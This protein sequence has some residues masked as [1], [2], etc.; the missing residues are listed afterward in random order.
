MIT[1][2]IVFS[3]EINLSY[4]NNGNMIQGYG[5]YYEYNGFNQL[6]QVRETNIIGRILEQYF[7]DSDGNR[8]E[9]IEFYV[10]GSNQTTYYIRKDFI[11]VV[12]IS[13][14]FNFSYYYDENALIARKDSDGKKYYYHSD[15]LGS[16]DTVTNITGDIVE[17][18]SYLP[19]GEV[20]DGG[21]SRFLYTGQEKDMGTGLYYYG[22][23]YYDPSFKHFI[24][25]DTVIGDI[26]NPQD[27]NHYSYV[28]N[29]PYRY[30]DLQD[31]LCSVLGEL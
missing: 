6:K 7:Y 17:K 4:D 24:Q 15:N 16:T 29:N 22:A 8:I 26:Y 9:K 23:R 20:S 18:T 1:I 12:N 2:S 10:D 25:P 31:Y 28:R 27:L 30:T 14:T 13:G 21:S 3:Q 11:Q 5:K 19:Y